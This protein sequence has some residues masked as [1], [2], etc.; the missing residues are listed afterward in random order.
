MKSGEGREGEG[1]TAV[2]QER[3]SR[4]WTGTEDMKRG[5]AQDVMVR[6]EPAPG[7]TCCLRRR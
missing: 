7:G 3:M 6:P 1:S 4:D 2:I 5:G